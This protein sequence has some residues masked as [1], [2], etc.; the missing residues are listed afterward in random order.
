MPSMLL[1][2][3]PSMHLQVRVTVA[4]S[5]LAIARGDVEGAL[6][7]L[8]KIPD[9]SPHYTRARMAMADIFLRSRKDK[10][11]THTGKCGMCGVHV[12]GGWRAAWDRRSTS[13]TVAL[14]DHRSRCPR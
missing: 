6:K 10:V 13:L 2:H 9:M 3:P 14:V 5:E 11:W 1:M 12:W 7:K 4:D 8:R